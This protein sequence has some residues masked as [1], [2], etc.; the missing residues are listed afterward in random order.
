MPGSIEKTQKNFKILPKKNSKIIYFSF[1]VQDRAT[2]FEK[3][4]LSI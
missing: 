4:D 2:Q 3:N 1:D